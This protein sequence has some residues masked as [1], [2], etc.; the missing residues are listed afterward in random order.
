MLSPLPPIFIQVSPIWLVHWHMNLKE[1]VICVAHDQAQL[2][3]Q[4]TINRA[5]TNN[6]ENLERIG[7]LESRNASIV[8]SITDNHKA[9]MSMDFMV[10]GIAWLF[11]R[12][13]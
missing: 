3:L 8:Q 12:E 9:V 13:G 5:V 7:V 4:E 1:Q 11:N 2:D 6:T 10:T